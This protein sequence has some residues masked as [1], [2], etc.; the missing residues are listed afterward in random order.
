MT[1]E[2]AWQEVVKFARAAMQS[3]IRV[4]TLQRKVANRVTDVTASSIGRVSV[5]G[6]TNDS[7]VTKAMVIR[8]WNV[9]QQKG[10]TDARTARALAFTTALM[11][12]AMPDRLVQR[13]DTEIALRPG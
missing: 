8:A 3:D 9:L 12:A 6:R 7:R 11:L 2:E 10:R 5:E 13:G 1:G 4:H